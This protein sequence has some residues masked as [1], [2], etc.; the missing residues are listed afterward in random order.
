MPKERILVADDEQA[1]CE[2]C[3][4]ALRLAGYEAQ[5]VHSAEEALQRAQDETFDLLLTDLKM[6]RMSGLE[7]C[8]RLHGLRP[9]MALVVM[10]GFG[11]MESAIEALKLGVSEFILKPFRPDELNTTVTR[12]LTRRRLEAENT[13]LKTLLPLLDLSRAFMDSAEIDLILGNVVRIVRAELTADRVSIWLLDRAQQLSLAAHDDHAPQIGS[14]CQELERAMANQVARMRELRTL[15]DAILDDASFAALAT[16][17]PIKSAMALPIIHQDR[18]LGVLLVGR[19]QDTLPFTPADNEFL[20][21]L[22]GQAAAALENARLIQEI[23]GA[24]QRLA[25]LDHLKS[26]F[27]SIAS[28]EL[29]TPLAT[30]LAYATILED[31]I[32]GSSREYLGQVVDS[33]MQLKS[34]IDEMVS[35]RRMDA[36]ETQVHPVDILPAELLQPIAEELISLARGKLL[37]VE[38]QPLLEP[39]RVRTDPQIVHL[40]L[41]HLL[42]NAIKFTPEHG[43]ITLFTQ[44]SER[45]LVIAMR[46]TGIGIP[47][48]ALK[49]LFGRFYQVEDSL[50]REHGGIGLGLAIAHE[51]ADLIDGRLWVES[52]LG[53]GSTFYLAL[54]LLCEQ[55]DTHQSPQ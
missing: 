27:I 43:Q 45:E 5:G 37:Q 22:A 26:E 52:T 30:L 28:H 12:A 50:R 17:C 36:R 48:E 13:R 9:D 1:V 19:Q 4:R 16:E 7:A 39:A 3:V 42:S 33:A 51:M 35:L 40:I 47:E 44:S 32:T 24:Y 23:Q 41:G 54:P 38:I 8:R 10:T 6:P 55:H 14:D 46:D 25:E 11:T 29:R 34:I 18:L 31:E 2:M 21:V 49:H 53:K 20:S 15:A